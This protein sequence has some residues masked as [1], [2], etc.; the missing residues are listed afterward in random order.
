M[1][2]GREGLGVLGR[3]DRTHL[4][5]PQA[6][7]PCPHYRPGLRRPGGRGQGLS[8][9]PGPPCLTF[10]PWRSLTRVR[11]GHPTPGPA[12]SR[13]PNHGLQCCSRA[14]T[15]FLF[16]RCRGHPTKHCRRLGVGTGGRCGQVLPKTLPA[17]QTAT[18]SRCLQGAGETSLLSLPIRLRESHPPLRTPRGLTSKSRHAE[19]SA[20]TYTS[21]RQW[22]GLSRPVCGVC[23]W[24]PCAQTHPGLC[25]LPWGRRLR[26]AGVTCCSFFQP[27]PVGPDFHVTRIH[28]SSLPQQWAW[29]G[30]QALAVWKNVSRK[31]L[32]QVFGYYVPHVP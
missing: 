13:E 24:E 9:L 1:A 14:V 19:V 17:V 27:H 6:P 12:C 11:A 31:I 8:L 7:G 10:S 18:S 4:G 28:T 21:G 3:V 23:L 26:P 25:S 2:L 15:P 22:L 30:A 32:V 29:R 5:T 20:S 16:P